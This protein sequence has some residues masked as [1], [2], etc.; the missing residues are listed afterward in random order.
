MNHSTRKSS[1]NL[2]AFPSSQ[3]LK[4][5]APE[6]EASGETSPLPPTRET[7]SKG[8]KRGGVGMFLGPA[9]VAVAGI[10]LLI[11]SA[12][13]ARRTGLGGDVNKTPAPLPLAGASAPVQKHAKLKVDLPSPKRM[14]EA[15]PLGASV[16]NLE[17]GGFVVVR[18]LPDGTKLSK[19]RFVAGGDWWISLMELDSTEIQPA[20]Q[21]VGPMDVVVELRLADMSLIDQRAMRFEWTGEAEGQRNNRSATAAVVKAPRQISSEELASLLKRGRDLIASGDFAA[22]RLVLQRAAA[23]GNAQAAFLIAGTYDP[24]TLRRLNAH[25]FSPDIAMARYW[26]EKAEEFGSQDAPGKLKILAGQ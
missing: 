26:Y 14:G 1:D 23:A 17:N 12:D 16:E 7:A 19:G 4:H 3:N 13:L 18:G 21:F 20:A 24:E 11:F 22:A 9:A 2:V 6:E 15:S 10:A 8:S 25:G 5:P